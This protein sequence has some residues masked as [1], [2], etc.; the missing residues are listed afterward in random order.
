[1]SIRK[2]IITKRKVN[3]GANVEYE[4]GKML[5]SKIV[6]T[7]SKSKDKERYQN[8]LKEM[9]FNTLCVDNDFI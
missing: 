7:Y 6:D 9:T 5:G 1:M 2:N 8:K 3:N 4:I